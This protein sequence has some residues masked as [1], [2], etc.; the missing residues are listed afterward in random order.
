MIRSISRRGLLRGAAL[1]AALLAAPGVPQARDWPAKPVNVVLGFPPGGGADNFARLLAPFL[2]EQLGQQVL[3]ENRPGANGNIAT[4]YVINA[5]P[6]GYTVLLSTASA[7]AA[8]SH[9]FPDLAFDPIEDL[10]PVTLATESHYVLIVNKDLPA[11]TWP[12]FVELA[13]SE[14]GKLVHACVGVG[15]VNEYIVDLLS[16]RAGIEV[17]TVQYK[18]GGPAITDVL[19][20]QAQMMMS[21]ISQSESF[22]KSDQVKGIMIA[23][24]ERASQL[25]DIPAS[26]EFG[27]EGVDQM[28]FWLGASV[29][30]ETPPEII[31]ALNAG[32]VAA[33][34]DP[35]L[36]EKMTAMGL[37]LVGSTPAAY[38]ARMRSDNALYGEV[39]AAKADKS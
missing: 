19:A 20:N 25:P 13:K 2:S 21:S 11:D 31:A 22:L 32:I 35:E 10:A 16:L 34:K 5:A 27:L 17:N 18:G 39:A 26:A 12:E 14:P 36:V 1:A 29:P 38:L 8:A 30:K 7:M 24:P 23:A 9:S 33:M 3:V 4:E 6:D 28:A 37:T 15:S